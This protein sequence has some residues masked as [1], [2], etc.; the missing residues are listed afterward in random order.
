[1]TVAERTW[2]GLRRPSTDLVPT[3]RREVAQAAKPRDDSLTAAATRIEK[4]TS[5][6]VRRLIQPWQARAFSYYDTI[7]EVNFASQFYSRTLAKVRLFPAILDANGDPEETEDPELVDLWNRVQDPGGGR[8]ELQASYGRLMFVIGEG[9]LTCT[10]DPDWEEIW[11]FLSPNELRVQP[12]GIYI[13][14]RAPQIGTEEYVNAANDQFVPMEGPDG[15]PDE[16]VAYRL[17][18]KHPSYSWLADS[19]MQASSDILE[20]L[21]LLTLAIRSQAKSRAANNKILLWPDEASN[22][23]L[24]TE[25]DEDI[26]NDPFYEELVES[27]MA[28]IANPGTASAAVPLFVRIGSQFIPEVNGGPR[29]LTL[30]DAKD[31]YPERDLRIELIR[32]FAMGADLPPEVLLGMA[33]ANHWTSWMIDEQSWKAYLMPVTQQMCNDFNSAYLRPAAKEAGY[34]DWKRVAIGYDATEVINH[35]DKGKD[36]LDLYNSRAV[37]KEALRRAKGATEEDAM[38]EDELNEAI[39]ILLRDGSFAKWGI[40]Q[41]RGTGLEPLPGEIEETT[42]GGTTTAPTGPVTGADTEK[43]PPAEE[44]NP[45]EPITAAAVSDGALM[46]ARIAGAAEV[47]VDRCRE[48]AGNKLV[49][50]VRNSGR[51]ELLDLIV[52]I[53]KALVAATLGREAL[54]GLDPPDARA[55]VARGS[56]SFIA[57]AA[58][59]GLTNGYG[60]DLGEMIEHHAARTLYDADPAPLPASFT[61]H[62]QRLIGAPHE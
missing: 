18:R 41:I 30:H 28:P 12:G 13:R 19:C 58:R 54:A 56:D 59:M 6:D 24:D 61:A 21:L 43:G 14:Y 47:A 17:W 15:T 2:F 29:L 20:E 38:P 8:A 23:Q 25:G 1:M 33:D 3:Y 36:F 9:Y 45:R 35:P 11:E 53:E 7:P 34:A 4:S 44:P 26:A 27:I 60:P 49:T 62:V 32:R 50:K 52:G 22:P 10:P 42:G 57:S 16:I 39:G 51:K 31:A 55:L 40:P 37:S 5:Q 46:A 48:L